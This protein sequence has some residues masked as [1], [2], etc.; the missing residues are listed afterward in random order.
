MTNI[1]R[2]KPMTAIRECAR[3]FLEKCA[4]AAGGSVD[5][6]VCT[7]ILDIKEDLF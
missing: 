1:M 7:Y 2:K 6:Y 3:V 4:A 5:V